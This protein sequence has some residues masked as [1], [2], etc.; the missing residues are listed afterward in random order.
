MLKT[1]LY[2]MFYGGQ[3]FFTNFTKLFGLK[4][5]PYYIYGNIDVNLM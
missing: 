2:E 1:F 4:Y 5:F 3:Q